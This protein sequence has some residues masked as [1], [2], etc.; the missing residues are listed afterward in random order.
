[1]TST[2]GDPR[3]WKEFSVESESGLRWTL[4]P[5]TLF[6]L[7]S[8]SEWQIG[9]ES[10]DEQK[11]EQEMCS[12]EAI[13]ELPEEL[14]NL[15]RFVAHEMGGPVTLLPRVA[16]RPLVAKPR[17]PLHVLPGE[18]TKV[19]VSA[20]VWVELNV[21]KS[22]R[23]LRELPVKRL[24]DTWFGSSTLEG[25]VAYALKT[26]ARSQLEEVPK[27][28]YRAITP[29][30][31]HNQA[32]DALL[33]DRMNLPVPY[34][35]MYAT[36][37][38]DLWTEAVTLVREQNSAMAALDVKTGA[39]HEAVGAKRVSEPRK[40]AEES[41]LVRAFSTLLRPFHEEE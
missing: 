11:R 15:E 30:R 5:L 1:M 35:S 8:G 13:S 22:S 39:P 32:P 2:G 29:I 27:R 33:L 10:S 28:A 14:P 9:H 7:R 17:M 38:G 21:G 26:Q 31:I 34:L 25:E 37:E 23:S 24:S 36:H 40:A 4:G 18:T 3:W 6:V 16:D 12:V 20:P 41:V 19:Y